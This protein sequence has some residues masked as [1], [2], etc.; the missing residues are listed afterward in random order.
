MSSIESVKGRAL[1]C[2]R[3]LVFGVRSLMALLINHYPP[4]S[5]PFRN[6]ISSGAEVKDLPMDIR[7]T[8][9][10]GNGYA[11]LYV[12]D[13]MPLHG[14]NA[15]PVIELNLPDATEIGQEVFNKV[16]GLDVPH[17][18]STVGT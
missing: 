4:T 2:G 11:Y 17:L 3:W 18:Q 6:S 1:T 8:P 13:F 12:R 7:S 10:L 14:R 15:P 5:L 16:T 9:L